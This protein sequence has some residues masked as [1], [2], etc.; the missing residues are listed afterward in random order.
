[1]ERKCELC[2]GTGQY[3]Y[4]KGE[5]RFLL[6]WEECPACCG[7][8]LA[9]ATSESAAD[10]R[11]ETGDEADCDLPQASWGESCGEVKDAERPER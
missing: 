10:R 8:G 9:D 2:N 5:S 3:G 11:G 7:T 4:F 6:S 1:M